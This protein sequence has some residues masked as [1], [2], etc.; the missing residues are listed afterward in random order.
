MR[1]GLKIAVILTVAAA[2]LLGFWRLYDAVL[3][4]RV[5]FAVWFVCAILGIAAAVAAVGMWISLLVHAVSKKRVSP[6]TVFGIFAG[7]LGAA[8]AVYGLYDIVHPK[9]LFGGM[10]G[11]ISLFICAPVLFAAVVAD[12]V[13]Y[14]IRKN[15]K[16]GS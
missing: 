14:F 4:D 3:Y 2:L 12:V 9:E 13:V 11:Y 7:L 8:A 1:I 6:Y 5:P 10:S 15:K 16:T